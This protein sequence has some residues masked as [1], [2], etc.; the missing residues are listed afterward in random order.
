MRQRLARA[1]PVIVVAGA[2]LL[3]GPVASFAATSSR[4]LA[5]ADWP[6]ASGIG[7][8]RFQF[9]PATENG[10]G[11]APIVAPRASRPDAVWTHA[12]LCGLLEVQLDGSAI[13]GDP[14]GYPQMIPGR[15]GGTDGGGI[16]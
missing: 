2:L 15:P 13:G 4:K 11:G 14:D 3:A 10:S 6:S 12:A 7:G 16:E 1:L 5:Y 9:C 8:G